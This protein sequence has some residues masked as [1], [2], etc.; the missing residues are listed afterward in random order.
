MNRALLPRIRMDAKKPTGLKFKAP[1]SAVSRWQLTKSVEQK[2]A[3]GEISILTEIGP[4][5]AGMVDAA[6]IQK[7]LKAIGRAPVHL[8]LNSP[9]GDAFEGIAIYNLLREH[10]GKITVSVLGMAA[11]AASIIAMAGDRIEMGEASFMMIHSAA[12]MVMGNS[13]DMAEFAELLATIDQA[14]A[15]LYARRT[16][17]PVKEVLAMMQKE[18][19]LTAKE[20]VAKGFA[21]VAIAE[22]ESDK[23]KASASMRSSSPALAASVLLAASGNSH[24]PTVAMSLHPPGVS[25]NPKGNNM[26]TLPEQLAELR[27]KK[28]AMLTRMGEIT[29][30]FN[31]NAG[32]VTL[33][34]RTEFDTLDGEMSSVDDQIRIKSY[35]LRQSQAAQ[36]PVTRQPGSGIQSRSFGAPYLNTKVKD[37]DEKFKGQNFTRKIIANALSYAYMQ[38][39]RVIS[40]GEIAEQRWGKTNPTLVNLIKMAAVPGAGTD[41]GEWGSELVQS[42]TRYTGDFLEYLY[43][44]TVFDRLP[45]REVPSNVT[46]KGTDG[47]A[48]GYWVGQ[49]KAIPT[50][51]GSAS[52]IALTP[53]KVGA[54][55]VASNEL[56][57]DSSPSA[58]AWIRDLLA[59]AL[60]QRVDQ[61]FLS[62]S[63]AVSGVSPA[64]ILNGVSAGTSAGATAD[65]I[66]TDLEVLASGFIQNKN[67]KNLWIVTSPGLLFSLSLMKNSLGQPEFSGL[68]IEGGKLEGINIIAGDNVGSGDVIML[69]PSEIWKIGDS[70]LQVSFSRDATIEQETEPTGATDTPVGMTTTNATNMFQ[71]DSTAIRVIRRINFQKRRPYA[72]AF[73]GDAAYGGVAS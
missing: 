68:S 41:S 28:E 48:T 3:A 25:G 4:E 20:A 49:S 6:V 53:L 46:I 9:G 13:Q 1:Q 40:A 56:L 73:I 44:I 14:G 51:S 17:L 69:I 37:Q 26:K 67:V 11:S 38:Q 58:E 65:N 34:M 45:L 60:A 12:G 16:G 63:A 64:G 59:N 23:K 22:P 55:A 7:Q 35:E 30:Q 36:P 21:D 72:A 2:S 71:E 62:A 66:R 47:A 57:A 29:Q 43:G 50:T 27:E 32:G 19:W 10:P 5:W 24:R 15:E 18:T 31:S 8:I 61:T 39:G 54:I 42:D 33:E 70:G 52:S